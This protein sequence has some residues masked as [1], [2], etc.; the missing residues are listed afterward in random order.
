MKDLSLSTKNLPSGINGDVGSILYYGLPHLTNIFMIMIFL[1]LNFFLHFFGKLLRQTKF[2]AYSDSP[3][4]VEFRVLVS[5][6]AAR[7][8]ILGHNNRVFVRIVSFMNVPLNHLNHSLIN[9][10]LIIVYNKY[11]LRWRLVSVKTIQ[12]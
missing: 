10:L 5:T 4:I 8:S 1:G 9:F 3:L 2:K 6:V 12:F 7:N 11:C